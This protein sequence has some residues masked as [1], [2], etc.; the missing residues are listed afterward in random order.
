MRS[1]AR[2]AA[3]QAVDPNLVG[4]IQALRDFLDEELSWVEAA[5]VEATAV[6]ERPG[7]DAARHLVVRGGKRVRPIALLLSAACFGEVTTAAR[8]LAVVAELVHTATLLHDDVIDEGT[9]RRGA[10]TA[11]RVWGNAVSVLAGDLLLVEALDRTSRHAPDLLPSLFATLRQL[12]DGEIVQLRGRAEL[13]VSRDTY[14]RVLRGKTASL[15]RWAARTGARVGGA[16]EIDQERLAAVGELVGMGFQLIDDALDY[17]SD[18]TE[19]TAAADLRDGKLTLPLVLALERDPELVHPVTR[20][21]RGDDS[22]LAEVRRRVVASGACDE[23]RRI[24]DA[25]TDRALESLRLVPR[26]PA[27]DLLEETIVRLARRNA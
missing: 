1:L 24:A 17:S 16:A 4:R 9:E 18:E 21:H 13:D 15:F 11:R 12:V 10:P 6:G 26:S 23:V 19:K 22:P 14:D 20:I 2:T 7:R 25:H 27:R 8:Q 3:V 5:L